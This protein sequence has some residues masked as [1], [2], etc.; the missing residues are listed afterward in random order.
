MLFFLK[1]IIIL[2]VPLNDKF[3][4]ENAIPAC[5]NF[6]AATKSLPSAPTE[7]KLTPQT[8]QIMLD[9]SRTP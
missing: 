4:T 3:V 7:I 1:L 5:A 6:H 9:Q 8:A 2:G